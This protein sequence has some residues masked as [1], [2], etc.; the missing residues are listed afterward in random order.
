MRLKGKT[1]LIAGASRNIGKTIAL[2]FARE[3][4]NVVP[5][6]SKMSD[7]LQQVA[8][9]CEAFGVQALPVAADVGNHGEVNRAAQLALERFVAGLLSLGVMTGAAAASGQ[10]LPNKPIRIV[11]AEPGGGLDFASRVLAQGLSASMARNVIVENRPTGIIVGQIVSKATPDGTTMLVTGSSFWL[12]PYLH[13]NLPWDPVKDFSAITVAATT[14]NMIV[15][16]PSVEASSVRELIDLAKARPGYLNYAS[17][18]IGSTPHLAPELFKN[19]TGVNIVRIPFKGSGPALV[20]V[21]SGQVQVMFP[22]VPAGLPHVKAG[23]LKALAVASPQPSALIPRVPTV[24]ATVA[25]YESQVM[26]GVFAPART[27]EA[28]V[29]RLNQE[30][31]RLVK[32]AEASERFLNAGVEVVGSSPEQLAAAMKSEMTRMGKLIRDAGI[33]IE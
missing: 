25:G 11:T 28:I 9:E 21:I 14:P 17:G 30:I 10:D 31:V 5:V 29:R 12:A 33:R 26:Y 7:E 24:A 1:A 3:G 18:S 6:A 32:T 20:A 8:R 4:A 19:M 16:H 27:P 13:D 15:A 2:T 22:T 23:R